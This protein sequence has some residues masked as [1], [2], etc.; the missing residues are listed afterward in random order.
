M[1][2]VAL[3]PPHNF[4]RK[5]VAVYGYWL[6][7]LYGFVGHGLSTVDGAEV[8]RFLS[9]VAAEGYSR[10]SQKQALCAIV[11]ACRHVL[12]IDLGE[13][14][15]FRPAPEFRRPPTVLT[16]EETTRLLGNVSGAMVFP[17]NLLYRCGLRLNECIQLRVQNLDVGNRRVLIHDGKGGK[18]REVPI[19]ECLVAAAEAHMGWRMAL[20]ESD[21][22]AGNGIVAPAESIGEEAPKCLPGVGLAVC[23]SVVGHPF[24][25]SM[26]YGRH[27]PAA[28]RESRCT[29]GWHH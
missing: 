16:R 20:H 22:K 27:A 19:P 8:G 26:V 6:R 28:R 1:S 3:G 7:R 9:A 14:D 4:S 12:R 21:L 17:A 10:T 5:T 23:F 15:R 2:R 18:H 25:A 29:E 24:R 11:F 13:I